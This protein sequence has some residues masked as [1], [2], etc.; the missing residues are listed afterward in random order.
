[1]EKEK[2]DVE[3]ELVEVKVKYWN[4]FTQYVLNS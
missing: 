4:I 3:K 2:E 1:V